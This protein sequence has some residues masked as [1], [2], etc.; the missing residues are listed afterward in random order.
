MTRQLDNNIKNNLIDTLSDIWVMSQRNMLRYIRLPQLLLFNVLLNVVLLL[1]F[2]YVFGGAIF[3]GGIEYIQYFVPGFMVQTVVFGSTQT[4]IGI[5]Q[6]LSKGLID[7][8]RSLPMSRLALF[9]GR[10]ISDAVRYIILIAIMIAVGSLMGFRFENDF[11]PVM[12]GVALIVLF[13]IGL[14]WIGVFIGISVRD[15]EAAEVAG[16]AWVFPFVFA[17]SIF[18]PIETMPSWLQVFAEVNPVTP[19]VDTMRALSSGG[20]ISESLWKILVWDGA[21]L[22]VFLSLSLYKY[23]RLT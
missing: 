1:L 7:R 15:V 12:G 23:K 9:A 13:G 8:F 3:T 14:T 19:M 16:F 20:G 11:A 22:L 6:D 10:V 17:S 18:V 21:I 5:A 2:N 4:S